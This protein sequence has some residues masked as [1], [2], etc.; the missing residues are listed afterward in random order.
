MKHI[1][2]IA[3]Y[4]LI[5]LA[6][7]SCDGS[8]S[9]STD[10]SDLTHV[11]LL[12]DWYPQPEHGGFYQ[13]LAKGYYKEAGL[14][15]EIRP[16]AN[17]SDIR[18][19]V[20]SGQVNFGIGTSDTTLIGISRSLPLVGVFPYFQH[21]PQCIMFH[22]ESNIK[23]LRDLDGH[24]VMIQTSMSYTEYML[25]VMGLKLQLIPMD[26]SLSRFAT[27]KD[28]I[29]Q[30][31]VTSEPI[32]LAEQGIETGVILL[33]TSGFDPY[34]HIYT[35]KDFLDKNPT[36]VRAF[37]EASIKGWRDF[38]SGDPTPALELIASINS[39][40]TME[41]MHATI[42]AMKQY[43]LAYDETRNI[44]E[45]LGKYD[46]SRL[47]NQLQQL[48]DLGLVDNAVEINQSTFAMSLL[49]ELFNTE[50]PK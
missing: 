3:I 1:I 31:F 46:I 33:S 2:H 5:S 38:I 6:L 21:D 13:A 36:I 37:A 11:V 45:S 10:A 25:K 41:F 14:D 17:I 40:Q 12:T 42:N 15:V 29:Q 27:N 49:P 47:K 30:C 32:H 48:K 23:T 7:V 18:P 39:Q 4:V 24:E 20:A 50:T 28:F 43:H 44:D 9:S 35:S 26:F 22:P 19:L 34:R 8:R 16:G